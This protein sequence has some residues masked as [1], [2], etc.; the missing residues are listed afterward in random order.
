MTTEAD[1][2]QILECLMN[3][4]IGLAT[5]MYGP[6]RAVISISN[7]LSLNP[8]WTKYRMRMALKALMA[9]RL[10]EY[11]SQGRPAVV[12]CGEYAE[13]VCEAM[14][15]INGYALTGKAYNTPIWVTKQKEFEDGL[16]EW[17]NGTY[18]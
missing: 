6:D 3:G 13:L 10:I 5:T 17:A 8:G 2:I 15:P 18:D 4:E 16:K 14:P 12:S 7:L 1:K 9:D 11:T